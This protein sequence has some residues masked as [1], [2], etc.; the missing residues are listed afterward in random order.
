MRYE[1]IVHLEKL[2][3]CLNGTQHYSVLD[4]NSL[5]AFV[6]TAEAGQSLGPQE[7]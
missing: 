3:T 7:E 1:E 2:A 4:F 6:M 5:D